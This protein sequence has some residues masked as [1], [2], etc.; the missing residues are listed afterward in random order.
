MDKNKL[1]EIVENM[2]EMLGA[3]NLLNA[4]CMSLDSDTLEDHLRYINRMYETNCF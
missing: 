3:D 1:Y 2:T 4:L